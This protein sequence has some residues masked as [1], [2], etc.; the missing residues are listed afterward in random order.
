MKMAAAP[1]PET[2]QQIYHSIQQNHKED[3][4]IDVA[5]L[6]ADE[7]FIDFIN[8]GRRADIYLGITLQTDAM[9]AFYV[10]LSDDCRLWPRSSDN[11]ILLNKYQKFLAVGYSKSIPINPLNPELNP[12]CYLL[13][14][15]G[16]H[17]FLHVSRIRA[18]LLS[19]RLLMSYIYICI[20]STHS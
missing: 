11:N 16:A 2:S 20:W 7:N 1:T 10:L 3:H 17:H 5:H 12:I 18:K 9:I 4:H 13:A 19:F 6:L 15:L 8:F 14:L